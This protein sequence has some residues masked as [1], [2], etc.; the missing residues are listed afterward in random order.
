MKKVTIQQ[1]KFN[2]EG[3]ATTQEDNFGQILNRWDLFHIYSN[4]NNGNAKATKSGH[5]VKYMDG[6]YAVFHGM[7]RYDLPQEQIQFYN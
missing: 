1:N 7:I 4:E 2:C 6:S 5:L 3:I